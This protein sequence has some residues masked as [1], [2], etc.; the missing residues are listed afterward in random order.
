[1][2]FNE[3]LNLGFTILDQE[4]LRRLA[5]A[6]P[7][8]QKQQTLYIPPRIYGYQLNRL[9]AF[10]E[11]FLSNRDGIDRCYRYCLEAYDKH[12]GT[13]ERGSR[14]A[15]GKSGPFTGR[16]GRGFQRVADEFQLSQLLQRWCT[17]EAG[18]ENL[19]IGT[20][21]TYLTMASRVGIA[22]VLNL[23][24]MRIQE[25][26][27]LRC[28]CLEI[29]CDTLLGHVYLLKGTTNKF[30]ED[31]NARWVTSP[32][33]KLAIDVLSTVS[34]LRMLAAK[35]NPLVPLSREDFEN[36]HLVVR[37]Y[38]PW[39]RA[40]NILL[41]HSSRPSY[42]SYQSVI[43][44][45]PFLFDRN[46]IRLNQQDLEIARTTTPTLKLTNIA[47]GSIWPFS[48]HQLRRTGAVNMQA[49]G[50]VSDSSLQYQLKH[51]TLSMSLYYG[52]GYSRVRLSESARSEYIR[53]MYEVMSH[54][55]ANLAS[56]RFV[57]PY[58]SERKWEILQ[59]VSPKD[60]IRLLAA[61]KAGSISWRETL[62]GGCTKRGPCE[63]GGVDN[64]VRCGGGD[65]RGPCA[66]ALYDRERH[67]DLQRLSNIIS[68]HLRIA[69]LNSPYWESL[70]AQQK[71]IQNALQ[72]INNDQI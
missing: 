45:H 6:L 61:A 26:W 7:D 18:A 17:S 35:A 23:S 28:N 34:R 63:Y 3:R 14:R 44:D 48:W 54:D 38:E 56:D 21:S 20:L 36:P 1:M 52:Q 33:A 37:P 12:Y 67:G 4:A 27:N 51:A 32:Y 69:P 55:I 71:A 60:R 50:L 59:I 31:T 53:T 2:L 72:T 9:R 29:E 24:L 70:Q 15:Q 39:A 30:T 42:P 64:I 16:Y 10:L 49:S 40:K 25:A 8:H 5:A 43:D 57:S 66:D 65:G 19:R 11:D 22:Y 58:G 68:S 62:L 47:V 13:L 46:I 41:P